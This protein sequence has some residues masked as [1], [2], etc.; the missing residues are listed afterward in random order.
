MYSSIWYPWARISRFLSPDPVVSNLNFAF[1][2]SRDFECSIANINHLNLKLWIKRSENE[3][4]RFKSFWGLCYWKMATGLLHGI[5]GIG[6]D[7]CKTQRVFKLY[8]HYPKRYLEKALHPYEIEHFHSLQDHHDKQ[9]QYLATLWAV[10]E[11]TIKSTGKRLLF[12]DIQYTKNEL[13]APV[14]VFHNEALEWFNNS[15]FNNIMVSVSHDDGLTIAMVMIQW[16]NNIIAL[17]HIFDRK[18]KHQFTS[19]PL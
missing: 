2:D 15:E 18:I 10:K 8:S 12:P 3:K 17:M 6:I 11:A 16:A 1:Y 4:L 7:L 13:K 9:V 19:N 14:L 5:R